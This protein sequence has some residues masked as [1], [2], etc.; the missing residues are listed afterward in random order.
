MPKLSDGWFIECETGISWR[1]PKRKAVCPRCGRKFETYD[2]RK[3]YCSA[4]CRVS[5]Y[6]ESGKEAEWHS[7]RKRKERK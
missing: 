7:R 6:K 1:G 3:K 4:E 5:Y 2:R